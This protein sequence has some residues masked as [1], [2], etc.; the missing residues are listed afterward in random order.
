M[1]SIETGAAI[2][3]A[4]NGRYFIL[5]ALRNG[6]KTNIMNPDSGPLHALLSMARNTQLSL[7]ETTQRFFPQHDGII[8]RL[9]LFANGFGCGTAR[10]SFPAV[11]PCLIQLP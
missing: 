7:D 8:E 1:A 6:V 10:W 5:H 4:Q 11:D 9:P 3:I 2:Q